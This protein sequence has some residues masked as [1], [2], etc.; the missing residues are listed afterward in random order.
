MHIS[1]DSFIQSELLFVKNVWQFVIMSFNDQKWAASWQNQQN[2]CAPSEDSDQPSLS[3]WRNPG[4]LAT[5]WA[6]SKDSDQMPRLI[7]VFA[8]HTLILLV[9]SW[10]SSNDLESLNLCISYHKVCFYIS[11]WASS[12]K[13]LF[14]T[15]FEQQRCRS[16]FSSTQSDQLCCLLL[17]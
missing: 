5:H 3:A 15:I 6:H 1:S 11:I 13:N 4:S 17:R 8:V 10:G 9:L 12:W 2:D 14:Y 7:C 16:A